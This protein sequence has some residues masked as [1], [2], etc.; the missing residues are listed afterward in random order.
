MNVYDARSW[1]IIASLAMLAIYFVFFLLAP[2]F[3]YPLTFDESY[4]ILQIAVPVFLG[5]LGSATQFV[6]GTSGMPAQALDEHRQKLVGLLV[7]GP[8]FVFLLLNLAIIGAFGYSNRAN[9]IPG[10]GMNVDSLANAVTVSL[11]ILAV[12]TSVI[13]SY[14]FSVEEKNA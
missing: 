7:R 9:A 6:F 14:L 1:I 12:S 11:S 8:V 4:R 3:D 2:A 5:Y 10:D 13:V